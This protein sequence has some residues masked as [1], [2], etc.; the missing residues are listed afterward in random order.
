M[1]GAGMTAHAR[2][3]RRVLIVDDHP[4][5]REGLAQLIN[6]EANLEVCGE[7]GDADEALKLIARL[8]PDI[9]VVDLV[10]QGTNALDLIKTVKDRTPQ[11]P[12]LVLSMH[13]ESLYGERALRA[14]ARGYIMKQEASE[15]LLKALRQ[16]LKGDLYASEPLKLKMLQK[17]S[18]IS[19]SASSP[20]E[21]LSDRELEVFE[22]IGQGLGTRQ[23]A[24]KLCVSIKTVETYR[25]HIKDK[26]NLANGAQL[27]QQAVQRH[28]DRSQELHQNSRRPAARKLS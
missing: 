9:A 17:F 10:L 4:I 20:V 8:K 5:V 2:E 12:V 18:G 13:D 22:L 11:V 6:R 1:R 14:G 25:A 16:V 15:N 27:V 26:L 19:A 23:I 3:K 24:D 21:S 28:L 7:A